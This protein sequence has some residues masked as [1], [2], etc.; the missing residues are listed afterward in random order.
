MMA[1]NL[2][3]IELI[4]DTRRRRS[5]LLK[6]AIPIILVL[7]FTLGQVSSAVRFSGLPLIVLFLGVLG[8]SVGLSGLKDRGLLERLSA[9]PVSRRRMVGDYLMANVFMDALQMTVPALVLGI[10]FRLDAG[11]VSLTILGLALCLLFA[12]GV[13]VLMALAAG[14]SGEVHLYSAICVLGVAGMSGLFFGHASGSM[15]M[16]ASSLPF[17]LL[18]DGLGGSSI[19]ADTPHLIVSATTTLA[20]LLATIALSHRLIRS[21]G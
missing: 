20:V 8:S 17:A 9:L 3:W 10:S 12:N 4:E 21:K 1:H 5:L 11:A 18:K 7:P 19:T 2:F 13:G 15:D 16:I 14:G 6:F